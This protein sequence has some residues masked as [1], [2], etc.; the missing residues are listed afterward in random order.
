KRVVGEGEGGDG[1]S[2]IV[3]RIDESP[4]R[5]V[6]LP[7]IPRIVAHYVAI[8]AADA[9]RDDLVGKLLDC[10]ER[11]AGDRAD[12]VGNGAGGGMSIAAALIYLSP[13]IPARSIPSTPSP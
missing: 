13:A 2:V 8:D 9:A 1:R 12:A 10:R 11:V 4:A 6:R 7:D 5:G 3:L